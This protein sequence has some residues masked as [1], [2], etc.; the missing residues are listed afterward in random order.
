MAPVRSVALHDF[1][2]TAQITIVS[3]TARPA[4]HS[5]FTLQPVARRRSHHQLHPI[6][7][8]WP[9]E[10]EKSTCSSDTVPHLGL[11]MDFVFPTIYKLHHQ[12]TIMRDFFLI[13]MTF[14]I[15]EI[16]TF[17]RGESVRREVTLSL[18]VGVSW[19]RRYDPPCLIAQFGVGPA[20]VA[21]CLD[22]HE[23]RPH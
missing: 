17:K 7:G 3:T 9:G 20:S 21:A 2:C 19:M 5:N 8:A 13:L 12:F 22:L 4:S 15:L 10:Q 14:S 6:D 11:C 18:W 1:P 23:S 16:T